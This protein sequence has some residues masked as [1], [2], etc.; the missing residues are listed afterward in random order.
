M[1]VTS[2]N[3]GVYATVIWQIT[4]LCA[5]DDNDSLLVYTDLYVSVCFLRDILLNLHITITW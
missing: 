1:L 2:K 3:L 5:C 4:V